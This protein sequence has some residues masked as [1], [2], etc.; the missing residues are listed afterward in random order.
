[1]VASY[2][3]KGMDLAKSSW[4]LAVL[5]IHGTISATSLILSESLSHHQHEK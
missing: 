5:L 2:V 4:I 1:M 3:G